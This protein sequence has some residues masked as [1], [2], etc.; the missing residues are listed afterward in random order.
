LT[1]KLTKN[2]KQVVL[3]LATKMLPKWTVNYTEKII[4]YDILVDLLFTA[5]APDNDHLIH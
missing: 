4:Y 2:A 5:M 3:L 1:E